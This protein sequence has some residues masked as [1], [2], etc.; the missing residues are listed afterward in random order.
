MKEKNLKQGSADDLDIE[1]IDLTNEGPV[2]NSEP[3]G[4]DVATGEPVYDT[5]EGE[6]DADSEDADPEEMERLYEERLAARRAER[7]AR[8]RARVRKA[9]FYRIL[10]TFILI[11]LI[12]LLVV[13]VRA[14]SGKLSFGKRGETQESVLNPGSD[15]SDEANAGDGTAVAAS[16]ESGSGIVAAVA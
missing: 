1:D 7:Q 4:Y 12:L 15:A 6:D 3:D 2:E 16:G 10:A 13:G 9:W 5:Y 14:L 11:D 8:H